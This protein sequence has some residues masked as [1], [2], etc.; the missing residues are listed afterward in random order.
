[1]A[2]VCDEK[3][4]DR[5][6]D[7]APYSGFSR[8]YCLIARA[9]ARE[10][11][12]RFYVQQGLEMLETFADQLDRRCPDSLG[13]QKKTIFQKDILK[14][15]RSFGKGDEVPDGWKLFYA[16]KQLVLAACLFGSGETEEGWRNFDSAIAK[17]RYVFSSQ[18]KW[19]DIGGELFSNLKVSKDW[20]YA[21]DEEGN[22]HKLFGIVRLSF[23]D[24]THICY[25]LENPRWAWFDSVRG[26][27]KY[28][29]ALEWVKL[30][31]EKVRTE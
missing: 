14:V 18:E 30:M 13:A 4:L 9:E 11:G 19:L 15:V 10:N 5:W 25:L 12:E 2:T 23:Y 24:M 27:T 29:A 7:M 17:C 20:N 3:E 6:L 8:R 22:Q 1:M 21:I 26:T 31:A 28:Q 16:Y